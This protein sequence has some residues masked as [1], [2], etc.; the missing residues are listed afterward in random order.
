MSVP[1][2]GS[3]N[4]ITPG[5]W[6]RYARAIQ[7]SGAAAIELN[8]YYLPAIRTSTAVMSNSVTSTFW[9]GSRTR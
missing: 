5:S 3:L 4:G 7:D 6:A 8:I 1:I 9:P 2:I